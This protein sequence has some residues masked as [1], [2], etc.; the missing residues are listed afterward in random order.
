VKVP[1][2]SECVAKRSTVWAVTINESITGTAASGN[3]PA[4][5]AAA[6]APDYTQAAL[7]NTIR[8]KT[9]KESWIKGASEIHI[10]WRTSWY[11]GIDPATKA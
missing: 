3:P 9:Q 5:A 7:I 6:T 1:G 8:V 2:V 4:P 11:N 10:T